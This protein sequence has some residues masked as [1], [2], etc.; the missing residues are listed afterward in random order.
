MENYQVDEVTI[1]EMSRDKTQEK[2]FPAKIVPAGSQTVVDVD[3]VHNVTEDYAMVLQHAEKVT[4]EPRAGSVA[5][6]HVD[7]TVGSD[8]LEM[9]FK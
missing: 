2:F 9:M 1:L 7:E 5:A 8:L 3:I 4:V 6:Q